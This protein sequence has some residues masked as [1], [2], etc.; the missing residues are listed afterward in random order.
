MKSVITA[1][2]WS[3]KNVN[4]V[5]FGSESG[6]LAIYDMRHVREANK[7]SCLTLAKPHTRQIRKVCFANSSSGENIVASCSDDRYI[8]VNA[9]TNENELK[10]K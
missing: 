7:R 5:A 8:K 1:S 2:D 6:E 3:Q 10:L 4:L 9:L